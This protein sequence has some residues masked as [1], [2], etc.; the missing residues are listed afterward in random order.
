M[1]EI[2]LFIVY[3]LGCQDLR[4]QQMVLMQRIRLHYNG[5]SS[6]RE[7]RRHP[8]GGAVKHGVSHPGEV[9]QA[10]PRTDEGSCLVQGTKVLLC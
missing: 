9:G 8:H 10:P 6:Q 1:V 2:Y 3:L 7:E 5:T 4:V